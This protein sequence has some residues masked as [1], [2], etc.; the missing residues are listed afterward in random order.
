MVS[1]NETRVPGIA[2]CREHWVAWDPL[3]VQTMK[4]DGSAE[5]LDLFTI[6]GVVGFMRGGDD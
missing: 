1:W 4:S 3:Q 5:N 6:H 2:G